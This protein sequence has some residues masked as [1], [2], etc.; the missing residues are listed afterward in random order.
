MT[1]NNALKGLAIRSCAIIDP[2]RQAVRA[3]R[4]DGEYVIAI[5]VEASYAVKPISIGYNIKLANGVTVYGPSTAVQGRTIDFEAGETKTCR[6]SFKPKLALGVYFLSAGAAEVLT[7]EDEIHNYV[8][9]DFVHD[10][11]QF[12]VGSEQTSGLAT[13]SGRLVSFTTIEAK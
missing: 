6:F 12:V 10:A 9:L 13:L 4:A 11:F 1:K 7:P 3:V 8:M 5:T 2:D